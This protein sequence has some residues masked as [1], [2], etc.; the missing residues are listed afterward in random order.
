MTGFLIR[1]IAGTIPVL[2]LIILALFLLLH[3]APGDPAEM[4]LSDEATPQ[5]VAEARAR[6]G[7]DEPLALQYVKFTAAALR[8]DFGDS[9]KYQEPVAGLIAQRLPATMELALAAILIAVLAGVPLGLVAGARPNSWADNLGSTIGFFGIS[10]PSFWMGIMLILLV[11]G[12]LNLLPSAGR[13][14]YGLAGPPITGFY[15]L[16]SLLEGRW[17]AARDALAHLALPAVTLGTNMIGIVLRV[18]RSAVIEI[19][20]ED[21]IQTARAKGLSESVILLRHVLRNALV[22]IITV[23]GLELGT[24][25]S[26]SII[27]E[28]V[29]AWPGTGSLLIA[30]LTARDYPLIIGLVL[31]YTTLFVLINLLIDICYAAIDPRIRLA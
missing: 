26:G 15:L 13:A 19:E 9:F 17:S 23:V 27:V 28:T 6:W 29:F 25:L 10:L 14:T 7:L 30:A 20:A 8:G 21:Y 31:V 5:D 2:L 22:V 16:D 1:R 3:A 18:T 4:L 24:L 12:M 11:S